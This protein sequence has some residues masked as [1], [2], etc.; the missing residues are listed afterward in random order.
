MTTADEGARNRVGR[1][2]DEALTE[3]IIEAARDELAAAGV[4][5]FSVRQVA[6]RAGVTRKAVTSRWP[7]P[8][9]LLNDALGAIDDLTFE[10][11]GDLS[12]DL[13]RL[14]ESF[15]AGL[16]SGALDL[17]LR[18]TADAPQHPEVYEALQTHVQ[19]PMSHAVVRAFKAAQLS[20]QVREGDVTWLVR[21]FVGALLARTFQGPHR[22]SPSSHEVRELVAEVRLWCR[23]DT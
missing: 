20:G 14:G 1:P 12:A 8:G 4:D 13:T 22:A 15:I 10:P 19:E 3:R 6:R 23:P 17:Q 11:T 16:A 21:G 9:Q 18:V 7:E 5:G 2:R